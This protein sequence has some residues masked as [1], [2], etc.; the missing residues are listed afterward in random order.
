MS[1]DTILELFYDDNGEIDIA[2]IEGKKFIFCVLWTAVISVCFTYFADCTGYNK[3]YTTPLVDH[4]WE[5]MSA[6][7]GRTFHKNLTR[8]AQQRSR[9]GRC[10]ARYFF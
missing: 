3:I 9:E 8:V 5:T 4:T 6:V 10:K 1:E 2:E 7:V